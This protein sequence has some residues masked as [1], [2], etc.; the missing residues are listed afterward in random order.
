MTPVAEDLDRPLLLEI[1]GDT[2]YAVTL[3]GQVWTFGG[4]GHEHH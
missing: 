1:I 3:T 2:A 4:G